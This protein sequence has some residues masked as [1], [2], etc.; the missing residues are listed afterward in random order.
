M[1][2]AKEKGFIVSTRGDLHTLGAGPEQGPQ[3]ILELGP[4]G[5]KGNVSWVLFA[6]LSPHQWI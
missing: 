1:V 3:K 2:K 4:C 6:P 5:E